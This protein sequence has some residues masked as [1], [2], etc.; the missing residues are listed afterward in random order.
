MI[1]EVEQSVVCPLEVLEHEHEGALLGERLE[2]ERPGLERLAA[3]I[4]AKFDASL[5]AHQRAQVALDPFTIRAA[6]VV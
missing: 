3:M 4:A 5:Q 1:D 2:E 6:G